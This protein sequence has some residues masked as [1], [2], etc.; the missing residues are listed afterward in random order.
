[1]MRHLSLILGTLTAASLAACSAGSTDTESAEDEALGAAA[2]L[3]GTA[4]NGQKS[5]DQALPHTNGRA[6]A[7]CHTESEHTAL[8][9]ASAEARF[10]PDPG[11]PLFDVV[12]AD[13]PGAATLTFNHLRKKGLVRVTL[14]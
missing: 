10:Q 14:T 6:C 13:D 9:P 2:A 11:D 3:H 4:N 8:L 5:F 7:T 1:M 12:D